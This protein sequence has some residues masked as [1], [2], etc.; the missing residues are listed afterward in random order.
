MLEAARGLALRALRFMA[1][2]GVAALLEPLLA[3]LGLPLRL[4]LFHE[5]EGLRL[6]TNALGLAGLLYHAFA[7]SFAWTAPVCLAGLALASHALE[8]ASLRAE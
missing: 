7:A 6:T 5:R 8:R 3:V 4:K 2:G 1:L